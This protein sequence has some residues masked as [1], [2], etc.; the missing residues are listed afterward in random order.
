MLTLTCPVETRWHPRPAGAKLLMLGA[1]TLVIFSAPGPA[2]AG[3]ALGV[4]AALYMVEGLRFARHGLRMLRPLWP[5]VLVLAIWHTS[6]GSISDGAAIA[7][8]M[9]AAVGLAN[10]VTMTTRLDDMI[11]VVERLAAPLARTGLAP[12]RLAV[13]IALMVRFTP[14]LLGKINAL[15][16]AWKARSPRRANWRLV[17]PTLLVAL[18]D[19][20][21]VAD[22][23]RARG[24]L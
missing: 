13:A 6:T 20:D 4:V 2:S 17:L 16:E 1:A 9:L 15:A 8:R 21:H 18:D 5:F 3:M 7:A 11:A 23:I 12:R 24:G 14:V 10:M 19:A 22:A